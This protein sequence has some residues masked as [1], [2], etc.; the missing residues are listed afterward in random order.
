MTRLALAL[1]W[2]LVSANAQ[3]T[4]TETAGP[5]APRS[6]LQ[7]EDVLASVDAHFPLLAAARL[8]RDVAAGSLREARGGFDTRLIAEGELNEG[9]FYQNR[10]GD[11]RLEQNTRLW[12]LRFFGGYRVGRGDFPSY[13]GGRQTNERGEI[14]GG[15]ELPLLRGG[16]I[17]PERARLRTAEI[18]MRRVTPEIE[19]ERIGFLRQ[20]GLAY[21]D[22][23]ATALEVGVSRQLLSEAQERQLQLSGRAARGVVPRIDLVDNER[24]ILDRAMRL[25]G[26][27]R[28][29]EQAAIALSLFLR[30][31]SGAPS[32]PEP[33]RLPTDF[34]AEESPDALDVGGDLTRAL[35][36][37]PLLLSLSF[38]RERLD[39][40]LS[41]ARN[42]RLPGVDLVVEGSNDSGTAA[43]GI[44]S[45]GTLSPDPRGE[46]EVKARL[47]FTFPVQQREA[48]GRIAVARA[49]LSRLER[50]ERFARERIEAE[51]RRTI[52]AVEA[53]FAQTET[54]RENLVLADRLR[55]A[56]ER[57]LS[58]GASNLIDVNI[59]EVQA[60]DAAVALIRAQAAYFRARVDYRAAVGV[61]V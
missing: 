40:A 51:I 60:A 26:A 37:H 23:L 54:A 19:L 59:R 52:A 28:D 12:G 45:E 44:S 7:L 17:D 6:A 27:E 18:G 48:R 32:I 29:A 22:W 36:R 42:D 20:A 10:S 34:P 25:L 43:P 16:W 47:R 50:R 5:D 2:L 4:R 24:L 46:A 3:A 41:L 14:R 53:A 33:E 15:V 61:G 58:L 21:W 9:G 31:G 30:D 38:E 55:L 57:K 8:Q 39:V 35:D 11:A 1:L 13:D 49:E 56:E